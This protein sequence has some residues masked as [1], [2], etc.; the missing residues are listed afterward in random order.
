MST[1]I[2]FFITYSR[3]QQEDNEIEFVI[4]EKKL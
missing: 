3:K 4:P 2:Y 1:S